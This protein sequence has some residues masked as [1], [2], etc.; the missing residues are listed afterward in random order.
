[1]QRVIS[2]FILLSRIHPSIQKNSS[3][4]IIFLIYCVHK[5]TLTTKHIVC[6][7][8]LYKINNII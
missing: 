8:L 5:C 6:K 7:P 4:I 1:M 3:S 2:E